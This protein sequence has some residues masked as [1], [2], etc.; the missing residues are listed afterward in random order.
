MIY[1]FGFLLGFGM[2]SI[3]PILFEYTVDVTVPV[4]A[5]TS[6]GMLMVIAS[7]SGILFILAFEGFTTPSGD[8]FP[9]LITL[10]ILSV[11]T[12]LLSFLLK[13]VKR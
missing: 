2:M 6:N 5:A 4:P 7:V 13:D 11:I 12:F 9:T 10:S 8:Y 3:G 1:T